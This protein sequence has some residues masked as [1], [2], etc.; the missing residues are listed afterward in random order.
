[1]KL[2]VESRKL[3][4]KHPFRLASGSRDHTE[5]VFIR[6]DFEG[7]TGLGEASLPPYFPETIESVLSF[8]RRVDLSRLDPRDL[9]ATSAYLDSL[10]PGNRPARAAFEMALV[11]IAANLLESSVGSFLGI[12][13]RPIYTAYTI[14]ISNQQELRTKLKESRDFAM[15]KLKLGSQDD[16]EWVRSFRK[17]SDK[18]FWVD[19]NQGWKSIPMALEMAAF[20]SNEGCLFIEQPFDREDIRSHRVL[21]ASGILPVFA[22]ESIHGLSDLKKRASAFDGVVVKLMKTGGL[23]EALGLLREARKL[24]KKT[25]MG[26]MAESSVSVAMARALAPLADFADLDGP[27]LL[28]EDPY[29]RVRY[30]GGEVCLT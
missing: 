7:Q 20:L 13:D 10:R 9:R 17:L 4:L 27:Y 24:G 19:V 16:Y 2:F 5:V 30:K 28:S 3:K 22:D 18:P 1:V 8:C 15:I 21:H 26:C 14:G 29:H 23:I 25:V 11:E 6:L 12:T